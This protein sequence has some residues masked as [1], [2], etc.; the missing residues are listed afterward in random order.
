MTAFREDT[1]VLIGEAAVAVGSALDEFHLAMEYFA[2][3]SQVN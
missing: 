2:H 1:E 3:L